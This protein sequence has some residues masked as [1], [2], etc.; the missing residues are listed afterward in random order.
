MILFTHFS[1]SSRLILISSSSPFS[2]PPPSPVFSPLIPVLAP[3]HSIYLVLVIPSGPLD[4]GAGFLEVG[5]VSA[6]VVSRHRFQDIFL[7]VEGPLG[8]P[9]YK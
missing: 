7:L 8:T 1:L 2:K 3:P 5:T 6:G 9:T 4:I